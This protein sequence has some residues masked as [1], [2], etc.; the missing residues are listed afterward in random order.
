MGVC[1]VCGVCAVRVVVRGA[2]F[3]FSLWCSPLWCLGAVLCLPCA[4]RAPFPAR[5]PCSAAGYSLF[6]SWIRCS[7]PF[8]LPFSLACTFSLPP[9]W[10]VSWCL[11]LPAR[12]SLSL[13]PV[14]QRKDGGMWAFGG[15]A[16]SSCTILHPRWHHVRCGCVLRCAA[17]NIPVFALVSTCVRTLLTLRAIPWCACPRRWRLRCAYGDRPVCC[18]PTP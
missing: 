15:W 16:R 3:L 5:V 7:L 17:Y 13:G 2:P 10:C 4:C 9:L 1:G 11:S 14:R 6:L 12:R 18:T 8:P